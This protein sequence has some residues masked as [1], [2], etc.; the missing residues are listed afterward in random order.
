MDL[1]DLSVGARVEIY[2]TSTG[3]Y[4]GNITAIH[5]D[6]VDLDNLAPDGIQPAGREHA[7]HTAI[8]KRIPRR[9]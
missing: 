4:W 7:H 1:D 3:T 5:D 9:R 8:V 6:S 2:T